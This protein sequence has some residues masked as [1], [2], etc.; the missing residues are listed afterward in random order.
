MADHSANQA[1]ALDLYDVFFLT[2][3]FIC[4]F[5]SVCE[6]NYHPSVIK[7]DW[8]STGYQDRLLFCKLWR[9]N[10]ILHFCFFFPYLKNPADVLHPNLS[11]VNLSGNKI[12]HAAFLSV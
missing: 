2:V 4:G 1:A 8:Q 7:Y 9:Q 12:K 5:P 6:V 3:P 11:N 10:N